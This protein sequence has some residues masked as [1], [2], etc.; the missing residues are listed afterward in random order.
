MTA[1]FDW[2]QDG[3]FKRLGERSGPSPTRCGITAT[4]NGE[5]VPA[6]AIGTT[7]MRVVKNYNA[8]PTDPCGSSYGYAKPRTTRST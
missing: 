1:F 4:N 6:G 8:S 7:R 5:P 3:V 2:N